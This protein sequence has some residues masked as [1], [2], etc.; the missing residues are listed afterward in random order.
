[1]TWEDGSPIDRRHREGGLHGDHLVGGG[2]GYR[3][4]R[5]GRRPFT[6]GLLLRQVLLDA[7]TDL[8]RELPLLPPATGRY[9]FES[10]ELQLAI[11]DKSRLAREGRGQVRTA[12]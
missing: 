11:L 6:T 3:Q 12:P 10:P 8:A 5:D 9:L 2:D 1:M 4:P 7:C